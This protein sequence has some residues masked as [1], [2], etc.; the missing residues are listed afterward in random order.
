MIQLGDSGGRFY[1]CLL[2]LRPGAD[3]SAAAHDDN[4]L[5][6]ARSLQIEGVRQQEAEARRA[7]AGVP[8]VPSDQDA[9]AH[10]V[11]RCAGVGNPMRRY[12]G[13][14]LPDALPAPGW[15]W[16]KKPPLPA[17]EGDDSHGGRRLMTA[18]RVRCRTCP[19]FARH[20]SRRSLEPRKGLL[21][22]SR[23]SAETQIA[24]SARRNG[25][26]SSDCFPGRDREDKP[27]NVRVS[28]PLKI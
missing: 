10:I 1:H 7:R 5:D 4:A 3:P 26:G 9:A 24:Q 20:K 12:A 6:R 23:R 22:K 2:V 25:A 16:Q 27:G 28:M 8:H 17:G 21:R 18:L 11:R 15:R 13:K 19:H 14:I